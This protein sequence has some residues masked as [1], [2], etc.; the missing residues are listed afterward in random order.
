MLTSSSQNEG[1]H[2]NYSTPPNT[3]PPEGKTTAV[4]AVMRGKPKDRYHHHRSN[5]HYKQKNSAGHVRQWF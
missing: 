3:D 1:I 5:K 4:I 2:V